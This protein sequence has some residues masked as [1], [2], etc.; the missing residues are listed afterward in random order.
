MKWIV[1]VL[2][3]ACC[4]T[5]DIEKEVKKRGC[6]CHYYFEFY[7][8]ADSLAWLG[9][10]LTPED[11]HHEGEVK[12]CEPTIRD[13]FDIENDSIFFNISCDVVKD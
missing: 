2:L 12:E 10:G 8:P 1:L 11:L 5:E 9:Y 3:F 7:D 13:L 6:Y 4:P